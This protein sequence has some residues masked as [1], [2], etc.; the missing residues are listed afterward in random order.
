MVKEIFKDIESKSDFIVDIMETD[1]DHIHL[2]VSYPPKASISST[3]RKSKQESTITLWKYNPL[4]YLNTSGRNIPS[5]QMGT[6]P[7]L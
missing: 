4:F 1:R 3:V 7:V 5:G 6:L 2:L